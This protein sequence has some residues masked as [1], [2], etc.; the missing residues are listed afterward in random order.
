MIWLL[1]CLIKKINPIVTEL[2]IRV[3]KLNISLVFFTQSDFAV[4]ENI[5]LNSTHY[6]IMKILNKQELQQIAFNHLSDIDF[7]NLHKNVLQ[8]QVLF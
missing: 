6:I 7:M 4:P 2:F 3:K 8:S 1:I 5:R